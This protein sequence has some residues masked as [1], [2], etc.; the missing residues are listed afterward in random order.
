MPSWGGLLALSCVVSTLVAAV[1][2]ASAEP[3]PAVEPDDDGRTVVVGKRPGDDTVDGRATHQTSRE[4]MQRRQP[5]STPDALRYVPG[6]YVQQ[7]AHGQGSPY[8]RGRTGQQT[9]LI[10]DG[11]RLNNALFRQGP[12]QYL[13]TVDARTIDRIEVV[14]GSASVELGSDAMA[15][16]ILLHPVEPLVDPTRPGLTLRPRFVARHATA[17]EEWGGRLQL[18]AQLGRST[19]LL[20]GVGGR[21]VGQLES[22]GKVDGLLGEDE[23]DVPL[24]EKAVPVFEEDGRTQLGTGFDELTADARLVHWLS[25]T[26]RLVAAAYLYRQ[27]D[28]PRTDQCPPPEAPLTE[29]LVYDEQFRTMAMAR[30]ELEPRLAGLAAADLAL[31]YQRQHE[32]RTNARAD[33]N[34]F[35]ENGGRDDIDVFGFTARAHTAPLELSEWLTLRLDYGADGSHETVSSAAWAVLVRSGVTRRKS[36][37]Q[38]MDGSTY[39]QGGAWSAARL[40]LADV[41]TVRGGGRVA[42]ASVVVP[43][44]AASETQPVDQQWSATVFNAGVQ[45]H[46]V[47]GLSFLANVEQGFRAPNLDDLSARQPTGQGF[48]LENPDLV[49]ERALTLEVGA[50][51]SMKWVTAELWAFETELTEAMG[52]IG[53]TCPSSDTECRS[54]RSPVQLVNL[55]GGTLTGLEG[56]VRVTPGHGFDAHATLSW[57]KGDAGDEPLSRVPPL[58]GAVELE[59]THRETG[60]YV[61]GAMRW[62]ADQDRLSLGDQVDSRIPFGGTPGYEVFDVRGGLRLANQLVLALILENVADTPYRIHGSS[63]NGAGRGLVIN[64]EVEL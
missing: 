1:R 29:C 17:D 7:T 55:G 24:F 57:A 36:R 26:D 52:R 8:I 16:A 43:E 34:A 58:N 19:G 47:G 56:E 20:L 27:F 64:V 9:L 48:Q 30:A 54:Q 28:A 61:G 50:Q 40:A 45:W 33:P 35:I 5:R 12:N 49:P 11:L 51:L 46:A 15:G 21:T 13:F 38:Y 37:G 3:Q 62:A 4:Q 42:F 2:P 60:L 32:R 23:V 59:W 6:V 31:G 14:R 22:A 39:L 10:F 53:A 18:D 41:V 44:D 25:E 63:V